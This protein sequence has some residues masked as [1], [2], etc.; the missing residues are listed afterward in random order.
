MP[1]EFDK[2]VYPEPPR[3]TPAPN[4]LTALPNPALILSKLFYYSVD[5]PVTRFRG[6]VDHLRSYN[7]TVYYHR[8][9]RRVKDLTECVDRDFMCIYEA[10]MQ[11]KRDFRV[12]QEILK[13]VQERMAACH[14][15]EG[16]SYEQN[17]AK[18][19]QQFEEVSKEFKSRYGFL[20]ARGT[21]RKALMKQKERMIKAR[22][23]SG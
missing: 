10:D 1:S 8:Q 4:K 9:Y 20:G 18:E 5:L 23:G 3:Q 14:Q 21:C 11:W 2:E 19:I 13:I 15:R 22:A 7:K 12:D 16:Y 17:C 6:V